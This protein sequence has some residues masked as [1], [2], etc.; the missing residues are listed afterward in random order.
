MIGSKKIP[1]GQISPNVAFTNI[2]NLGNV[3]G[4]VSIDWALGVKH[5]LNLS[6]NVTITQTNYAAF[7]GQKVQEI[8]ITSSSPS[9]TVT[10]V[11]VNPADFTDIIDFTTGT[12]YN[13]VSVRLLRS[14]IFQSNNF[15]R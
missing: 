4:S 6:G 7:E 1:Q 10:W 9:Y 12:T 11:D 13:N 2:V 15:V 3:T 8:Q 5:T 14:N